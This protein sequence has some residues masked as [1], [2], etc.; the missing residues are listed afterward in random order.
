[1]KTSFKQLIFAT[2]S[3][4]VALAPAWGQGQWFANTNAVIV[5]DRSDSSAVYK[6]L[7]LLRDTNGTPHIYAA[8]FHGNAV[9][10][11][12]GSFNMVNSFTDSSLP[13]NFAPFNAASIYGKLFVSFALQK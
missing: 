12:D 5:V 4:A 8:N 11:F 6:G 10:V 13:E 3:L 2:G 7:A 9:E 1:M